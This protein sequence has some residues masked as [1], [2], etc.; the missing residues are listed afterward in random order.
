MVSTAVRVHKWLEIENMEVDE[1]NNY[2]AKLYVSVRKTDGSYFKKTSLLSIRATLERHP[3]APK[4]FK[5]MY[6]FYF[7]FSS[8]HQ[9]NHT[10]A[11]VNSSCAQPHPPPLG[12]PPGI[13]IFFALDGKFPGIGTLELSNPLGWGRWKRVNALH[14]HC[15]IFHWSHSRVVAF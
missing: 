15:N 4:S 7:I 3:K 8:N 11:S 5:N 12:W 9:C 14:K 2:L 6:L 10:N 1:L 13:S